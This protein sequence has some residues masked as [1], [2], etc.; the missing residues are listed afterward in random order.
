M[1]TVDSRHVLGVTFEVQGIQVREQ[2]CMGRHSFFVL[3]SFKGL[4]LG[5]CL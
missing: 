5:F 2:D 1:S 3:S 4:G